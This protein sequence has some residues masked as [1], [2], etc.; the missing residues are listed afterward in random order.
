GVNSPVVGGTRL[1]PERS[2]TTLGTSASEKLPSRSRTGIAVGGVAIGIGLT[3]LAIVLLG[4]W[5][6]R[7]PSGPA[8]RPNG[9]ASRP[10]APEQAVPRTSEPIAPPKDDFVEIDSD[11]AGAEIWMKGEETARGLTPS[12]VAVARGRTPIDVLLKLPGYQDQQVSLD[13]N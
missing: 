12:K 9:P 5:R 13:A 7:A 2:S 4:P 6:G 11:P 10:S 3:A 1:L 8:P